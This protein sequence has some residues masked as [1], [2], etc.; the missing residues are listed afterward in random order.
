MQRKLSQLLTSQTDYEDVAPYRTPRTTG[1]SATRLTSPPSDR[2]TCNAQT[3]PTLKLRSSAHWVLSDSRLAIFVN[4]ETP[5]RQRSAGVTSWIFFPF[6]TQWFLSKIYIYGPCYS[7][8]QND[9][10]AKKRYIVGGAAGA[11]LSRSDR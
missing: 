2:H 1:C 3:W 6:A 4:L 11:K 7:R 5:T 9:R 10:S 8:I